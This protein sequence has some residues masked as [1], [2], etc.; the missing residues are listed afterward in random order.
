MKL[1]TR[2]RYGTRL[3]LELGLYYGKGPVFLKDIARYE[4]ISEK[5]LSQ[6][7]IPLRTA[8]L[9]DSFRGSKGGYVLARPPFGIT[10]KDIVEAVEGG[11]DLTAAKKKQGDI[12]KVSEAVMHDIWRSLGK[13]IADNL[14][15]I[16]VDT[17]I[18]M[19]NHKKE[20]TIMYNI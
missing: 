19:Y 13:A 2:A 5:Y 11:L 12:Q 6:I 1:S 8:G 7:V 14:K 17:L 20:S 18:K 15:E 16:T 9:V 10:L 3:M 4:D